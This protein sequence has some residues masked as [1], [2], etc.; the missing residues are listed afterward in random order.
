MAI[1]FTSGCSPL[2]FAILLSLINFA[3]K[4]Q[5]SATPISFTFDHF[6]RNLTLDSAIALYGDATVE[7]SA[8]R[9]IGAGKILYRKPFKFLWGKGNPGFS[10]YF[11]F[12]IS[13]SGANNLAFF[14]DSADPRLFRIS[15]NILLVE[16]TSNASGGHVGIRVARESNTESCNFSSSDDIVKSGGKLHSWV[17]YDGL[18]K[19][20]EVRL[21]RFRAW[22]PVSPFISCPV[23][24]SSVLQMEA[25]LVGISSS[26]D[27]STSTERNSNLGSFI[28]AW[29]FVVKH[30]ASYRMHSEPLDPRAYLVAS[31]D[32]S[33]IHQRSSYSRFNVMAWL[34]GLVCGALMA[35]MVVIAWNV[36]SCRSPVSAVKFTVHP[37]EAGDEEAV[38]VSE[39]GQL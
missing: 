30:G 3:P 39:K 28:Y 5:A 20:I 36:I 15:K 24:M 14:L 4:T 18:L 16:L 29:S 34:F 38:T 37:V 23:D 31:E 27:H 21:S 33:K 13:P 26:S 8:I 17:E 32:G 35:F 12:S 25:L 10:T 6:P 22:R 19:R 9:M 2:L 11:C 7:D 1:P